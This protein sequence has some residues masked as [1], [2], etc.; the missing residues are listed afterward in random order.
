MDTAKILRAL[1]RAGDVT[2]TV[3][4][5]YCLDRYWYINPADDELSVETGLT[6]HQVSSR[7]L[8]PGAGGTVAANLCSLGVRVHCLGILGDDGEGME[9]RRGL[10]KIGAATDSM[11]VTDQ[12]YTNAYTKPM[13]LNADGTYTEMSRLDS[14]NFQA[15]PDAVEAE[16][17]TRLKGLIR[18]SDAVIL[19]DQFFDKRSAAITNRLRRET[20]RLAAG[21]PDTVFYVDSRAYIRDFTDMIIKC[22][23]SEAYQAVHPGETLPAVWSPRQLQDCAA[24]L[25][26][27]TRRPVYI[28]LGERGMLVQTEAAAAL[29]AYPVAP[30]IDICGAGDAASAGIVI[31]LALGLSHEEAGLLGSCVSSIT[32]QQVGVTGTATIQ[33]VKERLAQYPGLN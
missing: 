14:R 21:N 1:D 29:P 6:A 5:D 23:A 30:P 28:T 3:F 19:I 33:Q 22:N 15:V 24:L 4:G 12:L 16:L 18:T 32:I 9:L 17:L 7:A 27:R 20:C 25:H 2:V 11:V 31:G 8:F 13:R 26:Q 10:Q